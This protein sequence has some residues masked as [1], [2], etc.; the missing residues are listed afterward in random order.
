MISKQGT[1]ETAL[2]KQRV[3]KNTPCALILD[4]TIILKSVIN[5]PKPVSYCIVYNELWRVIGVPVLVV[6]SEPLCYK[7]YK[8]RFRTAYLLNYLLILPV[9]KN[10]TYS[11]LTCGL[12]CDS[13]MAW[14]NSFYLVVAC[15]TWSDLPPQPPISS[16]SRGIRVW[17]PYDI[18]LA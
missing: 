17:C 10:Q 16:F 1:R 3:E 11:F 15:R 18:P 9:Y 5:M 4:R 8:M 7:V 2:L 14:K 13:F 6:N 12:L